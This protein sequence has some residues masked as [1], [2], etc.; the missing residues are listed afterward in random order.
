[1][2][3]R[4]D[5]SEDELNSRSANSYEGRCTKG[6]TNVIKLYRHLTFYL[7]SKVDIP[8]PIVFFND[9]KGCFLTLTSLKGTCMGYSECNIT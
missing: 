1:M 5:E 7:S 9:Y 6:H 3:F 4:S 2:L 8:L